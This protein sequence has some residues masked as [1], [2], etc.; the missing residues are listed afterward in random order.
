MKVLAALAICAA[1]LVVSAQTTTFNQTPHIH[2]A[3]DHFTVIDPGEAI[4]MFA[5]ADH[6]SFAIERNGDK[7]FLEPLRES[8]ATNLFVWTPSRQLIFEIDPA[9]EVSKMD[10]LV[11]IAPPP[12]HPAA[13]SATAASTDEQNSQQLSTQILNDAFMRTERIVNDD[14]KP[15]PGEVTVAVEEVF[16]SKNQMI[17][18]FSVHNQSNVPFRVTA[19]DVFE[20]RPTQT[21]ISIL[22]LR[23]HQLKDQVAASFN[24][25]KGAPLDVGQTEVLTPDLAPGENT[26]GVIT[27]RSSDQNPARLYRLDFGSF[28]NRPVSAEIVL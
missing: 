25:V 1:A 6:G 14:D 9:G 27:L 5:I 4:T 12:G 24:A 26:T 19:P 11:R 13:R 15:H 17:V 21:P 18:R 2:T 23:D 7:L 20:P 3:L 8:A 16:R 22:S 10:M 28:Q